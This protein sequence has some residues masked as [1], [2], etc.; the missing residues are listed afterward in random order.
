MYYDHG[1]SLDAAYRRAFFFFFFFGGAQ[2]AS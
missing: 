2:V 1:L